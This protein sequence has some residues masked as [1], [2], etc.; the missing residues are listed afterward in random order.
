MIYMCTLNSLYY[1][2]EC[3]ESRGVGE[4]S[5]EGD[6]DGENGDGDEGLEG[7]R[8]EGGGEVS[9]EA[10]R[11]LSPSLSRSNSAPQHRLMTFLV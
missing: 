5:D 2:G 4:G 6:E 8:D 9:G 10:C 1:V 3:G 11:L 7:N